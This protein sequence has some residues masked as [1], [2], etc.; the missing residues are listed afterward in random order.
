MI[1]VFSLSSRRR[2]GTARRAHLLSEWEWGKR[3][4]E[5]VVLKAPVK[6]CWRLIVDSAEVLMPRG[7]EGGVFLT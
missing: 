4:G 7:V 3:R 5:D 2:S 6:F 1:E